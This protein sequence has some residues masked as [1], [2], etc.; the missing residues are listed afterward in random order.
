MPTFKTFLLRQPYKGTPSL[1]RASEFKAAADERIK[2]LNKYK[3]DWR[4]ATGNQFRLPPE[5]PS[6]LKKGCLDFWRRVDLMRLQPQHVTQTACM[7]ECAVII[8]M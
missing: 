7:D 4:E 3:S 2:N 8:M 1:L 6:A 5:P